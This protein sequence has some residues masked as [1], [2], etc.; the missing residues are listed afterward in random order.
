MTRRGPT[1]VARRAG[2]ARRTVR[3]R[4]TLWYGGLFLICGTVLLAVTYGLVV[5]AFIG[6]SASNAECRAPRS[7]CSAIGPRQAQAIVLQE[8]SIPILLPQA[9]SQR[10]PV[11]WPVALL[12]VA[13]LPVDHHG[14]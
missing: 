14:L 3:L 5:Q 13:Q 9:T 2:R 8:H 10:P 4:L 1:G 12:E 7:G 6:N 11:I